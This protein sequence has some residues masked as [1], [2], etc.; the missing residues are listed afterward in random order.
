MIELIVLELQGLEVWEVTESACTELCDVVVSEVKTLEGGG[1]AE[2]MGR[3]GGQ[4]V[5]L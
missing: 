2:S 5:I 3:Q 4:G 1:E